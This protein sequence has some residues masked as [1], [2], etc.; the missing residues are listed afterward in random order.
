MSNVKTVLITGS[1]KGLGASLAFAF[2]HE[3]YNIILHGRNEERLKR[4]QEDIIFSRVYKRYC[5]VVIGDITEEKTIDSLYHAAREYNI[6][7]LI[8]NAGIYSSWK[9]MDAP[10]DEARK[11]IEINLIAPMI[12]TKRLFPIFMKKKSGLIININSIA[13]K[14]PMAGEDAYCASKHGLRGFAKAF[15]FYAN[16]YN[17]RMLD[18]YLGAMQTDMQKERTDYN[19]LI[20]P[21]EIA[22]LIVKMTKEYK[23]MMIKEIE[24]GRINY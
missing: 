18:I 10:E 23:S 11:T 9:I 15:R 24:I 4:L 3:G 7:I 14:Y 20:E 1:S 16:R 13:G 21:D 2:S 22:D 12:L 19:E 5:F 6:D 8:N 17:V